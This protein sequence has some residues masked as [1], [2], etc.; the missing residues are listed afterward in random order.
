MDLMIENLK[1]AKESNDKSNIIEDSKQISQEIEKSTE[2]VDSIKIFQS[3]LSIEELKTYNESQHEERKEDD[4]EKQIELR[5]KLNGYIY[6]Q[7]DK[8]VSDLQESSS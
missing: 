6:T 3:N 1:R 7:I 5:V 4:D 8:S 2:E